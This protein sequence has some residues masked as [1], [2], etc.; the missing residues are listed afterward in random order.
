VE[1]VET[2]LKQAEQVQMLRKHVIAVNSEPDFLEAIRTLLNEESY[3]V[4]TTNNVST[5]FDS[6]V[7]LDP[8][9]VIVDLRFGKD[10][11]WNLFVRLT[12]DPETDGLPMIVTSTD[13]QLLDRAR[14]VHCCHTRRD[15]LLKPFDLDDLVTKVQALIG[16]A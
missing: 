10:A 9:L 2:V 13:E 5:T 7:A 8:D 15:Y 12:E 16:P 1:P 14:Q 4:T 3:N 6:I 11:S